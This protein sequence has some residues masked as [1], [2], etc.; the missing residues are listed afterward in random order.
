M[1]LVLFSFLLAGLEK[2]GRA[3]HFQPG[4][5]F[6]A[7]LRSDLWSCCPC[8]AL[9]FSWA[10]QLEIRSKQL[11]RQIV[12]SGGAISPPVCSEYARL[13]SELA[14]INMRFFAYQLESWSDFEIM[15]SFTRTASCGGT[16]STSELL[17]FR[18]SKSILNSIWIRSNLSWYCQGSCLSRNIMWVEVE[19]ELVE[20]Y[21]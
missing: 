11:R 13:H 3:L 12:G 20:E 15:I 21:N 16:C 18:S 14:L 2:H 5:R 19:S 1:E 17:A 6:L 10:G 4:G 8:P 9:V 7:L